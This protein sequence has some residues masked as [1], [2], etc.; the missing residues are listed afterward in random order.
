MEAN[1]GGE[2]LEDELAM[3]M[4]LEEAL[5][6]EA[7]AGGGEGLEY[8]L[9][10]V[11]LSSGLVAWVPPQAEEPN[12]GR[13]AMA[14]ALAQ[15]A[16]VPAEAAAQTGWIPAPEMLILDGERALAVAQQHGWI[17]LDVEMEWN[18]AVVPWPG[19][20]NMEAYNESMGNPALYLALLCLPA[21]EIA[22]CR[23]VCRLWRDITST[24]AFRR[25]HHDHHFRTPM[26]LFFFLDPKLASLNLSAVDIRDRVPRPVL[27]FDRPLNNEVFR[28]HGSC[29]GIL[30]LSSGRR[31]YACNPCTRRWARLPPLHVRGDIIGFYVTPDPDVDGD[32]QCKVLYHNRRQPNCRYRICTLGTAGATRRRIGRPGPDLPSDKLDLVL[33][34]GIAPSY[35]IPPVFFLGSLHWPP[36]A[37]QLN[38]TKI[39][40]FDINAEAFSFIAPPRFQA[41]G[42]Q[43]FEIDDE[44]LAMTVVSFSPAS[45]VHVWVLRD[46]NQNNADEL[47]SRRY[48]IVVPVDEIN[49]NNSC[50]HNGSVFAVAQG[51]NHLVQ[52]PRVLLHCDD[53]GAV[54]QRYRSEA[55]PQPQ[56]EPQPQH[57]DHWTALSGHTI[58]ESLLLHT[59]ILTMRDTDAVDGDPPFF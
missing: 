27:R 53:Q 40:T 32:F 1:G 20:D 39:L 54:L 45:R 34:K 4:D 12:G 31:L 33:A 36:K 9:G 51:R 50:H 29:A 59:N 21:Q 35:K 11:V 3:D 55:Q 37:A 5:A 17:G 26:P 38:N 41:V 6:M 46:N 58:Q 22:R 48:S 7:N 14:A 19:P 10:M 13:D 15:G 2:G 57:A 49:A 42:R 43:V 8:E 23:C 28:V 52:C 16:W 30:L 25:Y 24:A 18:P 56:P 44:R 47:W